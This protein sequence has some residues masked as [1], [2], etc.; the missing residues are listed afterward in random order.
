MAN[1]L[2][3]VG[4][5]YAMGYDRTH[6]IAAKRKVIQRGKPTKEANKTKRTVSVI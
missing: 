1:V 2:G 3:I 6:D 4:I 5:C